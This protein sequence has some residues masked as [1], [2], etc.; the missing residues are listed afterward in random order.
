VLTAAGEL[1]T[2]AAREIEAGLLD[3]AVSTDREAELRRGGG[4]RADAPV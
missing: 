2:A 3:Q 1:P 4:A